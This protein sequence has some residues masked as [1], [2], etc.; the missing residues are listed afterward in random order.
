L[1]LFAEVIFTTCEVDVATTYKS[2][3]IEY[4]SEVGRYFVKAEGFKP[5]GY[6]TEALAKAAITKLVNSGKTVLAGT[7]G[8]PAAS[9]PAEAGS[10]SFDETEYLLSSPANAAHLVKSIAQARDG[11]FA[12]VVTPA[13]AGKSKPA[14]SSLAS[15]A[16]KEGAYCGK[17]RNGRH[18]RAGS[19]S[20]EMIVLPSVEGANVV[21]GLRARKKDRDA[22]RRVFDIAVSEGLIK[23]SA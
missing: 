10:S 8:S 12:L 5:E 6:V 9:I 20:Y 13:G 22:A 11:K 17:A 4:Q 19:A 15:R 1:A 18:I 7:N 16:R 21:D 14:P 3:T 23:K 2:F